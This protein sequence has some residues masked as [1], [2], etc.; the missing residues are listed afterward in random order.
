VAGQVNAGNPR[1]LEPSLLALTLF[2]LGVFADNP[3]LAEPPDY[4]AFDAHFFN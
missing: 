2:M 3:D 4:L 1:Q